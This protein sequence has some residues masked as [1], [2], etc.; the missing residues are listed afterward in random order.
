LRVFRNAKQKFI[1]SIKL[2][3]SGQWPIKKMGNILL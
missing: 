1:Q 2:F 3:I